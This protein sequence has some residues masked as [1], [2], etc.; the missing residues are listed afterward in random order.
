MFLIT[1]LYM[2]V[3][4][5]FNLVTIQNA[6]RHRTYAP[7]LSALWVV[8]MIMTSCALGGPSDQ[9]AGTT[10]TPT[11]SLSQQAQSST[12]HSWD[13]WPGYH[14]DARH[15][16]YLPASPDP[17]RLTNAWKTSLDGAVYAEPLMV[18]GH[19]IVATEGDTLYALDP[20]T[21]KVIWQTNVGTPVPHSS[22]PCGDIDPLGI[23]GT[24]IYD[25]A[26]GLV[27]AV[28]EM[29][30]PQ[31]ILVGLD[32]STG[33]V[34]VRRS[35]DIAGMDNA[36]H[37]QRAALVLSQGMIYVAYGGLAGDCSDY[38]GTVVAMHTN[39]QGNVFSYRVPT[40]R[41]GGIWGPSGSERG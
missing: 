23:T 10:S 14:H 2:D 20:Q 21:G 8:S 38:R 15:T 25:P 11:T 29:S 36:A 12:T 35:A 26:T 30:G 9:A 6:F 33:K 32:A 1:R 13:D 40:P 5:L 37:Q 39:G 18:K 19:L 28:A 41:E 22:L 17:Q 7:R 4:R 24:P 27:F 3:A 34:K 16:G 31:H